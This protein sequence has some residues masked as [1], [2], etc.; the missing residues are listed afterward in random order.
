MGFFDNMK[1]NK[2][3]Q[4]AYSVHVQANEAYRRGKPAEAKAQYD[5]AIRLYGEA[6]EAGC[7]KTQVL[8][9]YAVLL[10][11]FGRFEEAREIMKETAKDKSMSE[12][13]H[14]ELR[15]NYSMCLW[16]LGL[17]DEAIKTIRYAGKHAKN[18]DYYSLLGT[19]LVEQAAQTGE[20]EEVK[21]L[22]D[23]AMDYD[24]EDAPTLDNYGEYYRLLGLKA[25]KEGNA[26]E[27]AALRKQAIET[28]EKAYK[29]RPSQITTLYALANFALE[30]GDKKKAVEYIDKAI[31]HSGSKVCPVSIEMLR[32]LKAKAV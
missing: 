15:V 5:E 21:A 27:A 24:D 30:D 10:M 28:F 12:E 22:L 1:V 25:E 3:G 14:F 4:K 31:M 26:E 20:F 17:L 6:Y 23:E 19:F 29:F 2:L 32:E 9:A 11:R 7:R 13:T 8:M 18:S 16:R